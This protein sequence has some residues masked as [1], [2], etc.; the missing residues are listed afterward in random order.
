MIGILLIT[1]NNLGEILLQNAQQIV[2][3]QPQIRAVSQR[4]GSSF[5]VLYNRVGREIA[6]LDG[7]QGVLL[8]VDIF[9]GTP[10]NVAQGFVE[11]RRHAMITGLNMAMLLKV[12]ESDRQNLSIG[13]TGPGRIG[14]GQ[15]QHQNP[16]RSGL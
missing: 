16:C 12:L 14:V 6:E 1:H 3:V 8:M 11:E 5:Q 9:G 2:G 10:S 15:E 7:G 4:P 13:R